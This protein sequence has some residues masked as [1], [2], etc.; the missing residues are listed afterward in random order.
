MKAQYALALLLF[1]AVGCSDGTE[2]PDLKTVLTVEAVYRMAMVQAADPVLPAA[3]APNPDN[4]RPKPGD[5]CYNCDGEGRTG[6]G[7]HFVPCRP[8]LAD[9]R[10]DPGDPGLLQTAQAIATP[11]AESKVT[12]TAPI[13]EEGLKR[14]LDRLKAPNFFPF[15]VPASPAPE[16]PAADLSQY[17]I[18]IHSTKEDGPTWPLRWWK[19]EK[20]K[21]PAGLEVTAHAL[22][23]GGPYI[24][25]LKEGE[26]VATYEEFTPVD[27]IL[28]EVM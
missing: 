5:V 23:E 19:E 18:Q 16:Q 3:N 12:I 13:L 11:P 9:G 28:N 20:S 2:R 26:V 1:T 15:E 21:L 6:D 14:D 27:T 7:N 24:R 10:L 8:C 22:S 4:P 17:K 25:V